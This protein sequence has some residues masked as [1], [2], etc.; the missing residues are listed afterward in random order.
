M[1]KLPILAKCAIILLIIVLIAVILI[2]IVRTYSSNMENNENVESKSMISQTFENVQSIEVNLQKLEL[3]V[4]QGE[5]VKVE[6][7]DTLE[8]LKIEQNEELLNIV[9]EEVVLNEDSESQKVIIYLPQET[10]FDN[11]NLTVK[12]RNISIETLNAINVKLD[13]NGN[14]CTINNFLSDTAEL[15]N[16]S[17]RIIM[18]NG[19]VKNMTMQSDAGNDKLNLKVTEIATMNLNSATTEINLI[20]TE[21]DYQVNTVTQDSSMYLEMGRMEDINQTIGNGNAKVNINA[22]SVAL[23]INYKENEE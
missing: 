9:D 18:N 13:I 4:K 19:E 12:D 20:G 8:G 23:Y 1:K 10:K 2:F 6:Y 15:K 16:Q 22:Q 5:Q 21:E 3:E 17:G 14:Y 11:I 7:V